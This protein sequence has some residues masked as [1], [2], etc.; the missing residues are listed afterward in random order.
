MGIPIFSWI[1][2]KRLY[3]HNYKYVC[4]YIYIYIYISPGYLRSEDGVV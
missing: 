3:I 1:T 2:L 4:I